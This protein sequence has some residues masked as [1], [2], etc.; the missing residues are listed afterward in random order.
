MSGKSAR[1]S[2]ELV[3]AARACMSDSNICPTKAVD[4]LTSAVQKDPTFVNALVLSSSLASRLGQ[5]AAATADLSLAIEVER[6]SSDARRVASLYGSRSG[7]FARAGR[8]TDAV[9]D[10]R[11]ALKCEPDNGVWAFELGRAYLREGRVSLAQLSFQQALQEPMWSHVNESTRP[12]VYALYG[13]CCLMCRDY[14]KAKGLLRKALEAGGEGA[15]VMHDVGLAHYHEGTSPL[16]AV[17]F[18]ARATEM[19]PQPVEYPLHLGLTHARCGN[20]S[21]ALSSMNEAVLRGPAEPRLRFYRGCVELQLGL[22]PQALVDLQASVDQQSGAREGLAANAA[23]TPARSEA[24]GNSV[25]VHKI[26]EGV[27]GVETASSAPAWV[28][29]AL[30]HLFCEHSLDRAAVCLTEALRRELDHPQR[31]LAG[32]LLGVV[33][34]QRDDVLAALRVLL[35][36]VAD[37]REVMLANTHSSCSASNNNAGESFSK[38]SSSS[39]DTGFYADMELLVLTH[40]GLAYD[41]CGCADL[42]LRFF[43]QARQRAQQQQR[44]GE[45]TQLNSCFFREAV[46]QVELRDNWGALHTIESNNSDGCRNAAVVPS[47]GSPSPNLPNATWTVNDVSG[48]DKAAKKQQ[49]VKSHTSAENVAA[50]TPTSPAFLT[51]HQPS[52]GETAHLY[53]VTL[54]RLGRFTEALHLATAAVEAQRSSVAAASSVVADVPAYRYNRALTYFLLGNYAEAM[55][56]VRACVEARPTS[57]ADVYYLQGCIAHATEHFAEALA[58]LTMALEA[59]ATLRESPVFSYSHGVLLAI[60]GRH[61]DAI[62]AFS[63]AILHSSHAARNAEPT[64]ENDVAATE[65]EARR[66]CPA[67]YYHER[68]KM[69]QQTGRYA[70]ALADYDCVLPKARSNRVSTESSAT[71]SESALNWNA[72]VNR[73]LT[74]KELHRYDEAAADWNTAVKLDQSGCLAQ[75]TSQDVFEMPYLELCL[76]GC[77]IYHATNDVC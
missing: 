5:L 70:E 57:S 22:G 35:D 11:A 54:R 42:A 59:D 25:R 4:F 37:M 76:P 71:Q 63:A 8:H 56:D 2:K 27:L 3:E 7:L 34:H 66:P 10:L 39:F 75:F 36:V 67:V 40:V 51:L 48:T 26:R 33:L 29:M 60:A 50:A 62:A 43:T 23:A 19:D 20:F 44:H 49:P 58:S 73:A 30:V 24:P 1:T 18:F 41:A 52:P 47:R 65:S 32:L 72:L 17:E 6:G 38:A 61:E 64:T 46:A 69:Y 28:A 16:T 31:V 12:K 9:A 68:A 74:L 21:D 77:E 15:A 45:A 53:A 14:K 13:R 55:R